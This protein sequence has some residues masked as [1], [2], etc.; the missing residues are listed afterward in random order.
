MKSPNAAS[1]SGSIQRPLMKRR[2]RRTTVFQTKNCH[3]ANSTTEITT[4]D[5]CW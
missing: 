4:E 5:D 1:Q 2:G 3:G